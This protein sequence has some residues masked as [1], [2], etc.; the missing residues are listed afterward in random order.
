ML[1]LDEPM[2]EDPEWPRQLLPVFV[3]RRQ[4]SSV[5]QQ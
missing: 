4:K 2:H 1:E 3:L 5:V